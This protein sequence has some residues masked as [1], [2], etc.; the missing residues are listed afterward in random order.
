MAL[1]IKLLAFKK[2]KNVVIMQSP[3]KALSTDLDNLV[4][5]EVKQGVIAMVGDIL[6]IVES[7]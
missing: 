2:A 4:H 1:K 5:R 6:L 7:N 3:N